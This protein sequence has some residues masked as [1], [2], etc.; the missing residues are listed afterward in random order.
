LGSLGAAVV[1]EPGIRAMVEHNA[2]FY[3]DLA[4]PVALLKGKRASD[5]T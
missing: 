2:T 5:T 1:G 3:A 4:D